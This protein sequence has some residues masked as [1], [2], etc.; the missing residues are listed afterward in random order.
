MAVDLSSFIA[1]KYFKKISPYKDN[2][3]VLS[4]TVEIEKLR[5]RVVARLEAIENG[6][7]PNWWEDTE[8]MHI[9]DQVFTA[10]I[11]P[12]PLDTIER[13]RW[14]AF[15]CIAMSIREEFSYGNVLLPID[16]L[17][18]EMIFSGEFDQYGQ[19]CLEGVSNFR[20]QVAERGWKSLLK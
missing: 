20:K 3:Q 19:D 8:L 6:N 2:S 1:E 10:G 16:Y 13:V 17:P 14:I 4:E 11:I 5:E 9:F 18:S 12:L 7:M 15:I